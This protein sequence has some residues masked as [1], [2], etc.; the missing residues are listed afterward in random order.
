MVRDS[1]E[2]G[3]W[4]VIGKQWDFFKTK[5]SFAVSN[6]KK[7]KFWKDRWCSE[8]PLCE[9]FLSLFALFDLKEAWVANFWEHHGGGNWNFCFVRNIND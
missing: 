5:I 2:V 9:T 1:S 7:V 8:E 6:G 4:K 3:V